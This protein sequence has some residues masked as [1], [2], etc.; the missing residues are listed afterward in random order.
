MERVWITSFRKLIISYDCEKNLPLP[1][2]P[3]QATYYSRQ[4]HLNNFTVVRGNSK[5]KLTPDNVTVYVWTQNMYRKES[6]KIASCVFNT[7][8]A[9]EMENVVT[10]D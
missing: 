3:N 2:L 9:T 7:L 10:V 6:N 4:I 1:K 8:L 5:R